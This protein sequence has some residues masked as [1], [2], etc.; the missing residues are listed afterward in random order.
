MARFQGRSHGH[1][2][3]KLR[4]KKK[5]IYL[6]Y[7]DEG[8]REARVKEEGKVWQGFREDHINAALI[9]VTPKRNYGKKK[10]KK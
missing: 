6:Q 5:G 9:L 8:E 4:K 1:A 2:K 10:I 7:I 3:K